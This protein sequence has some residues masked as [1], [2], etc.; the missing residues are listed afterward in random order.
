MLVDNYC[1]RVVL[2]L[3]LLHPR[4]LAVI[5]GVGV[6]IIAYGGGSLQSKNWARRVR[7][8][9]VIMQCSE[10]PTGARRHAFSRM[11]QSEQT[12]SWLR[13]SSM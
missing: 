5:S 12:G 10:V 13:V 8:T 1:A 3:L 9:I 4:Y 6:R 11:Q 2:E 7:L